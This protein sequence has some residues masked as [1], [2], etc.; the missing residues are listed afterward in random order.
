MSLLPLGPW[1]PQSVVFGDL[2]LEVWGRAAFRVLETQS[3]GV[4]HFLIVFLLVKSYSH[5]FQ[6]ERSSV[7]RREDSER[8]YSALLIQL[9]VTKDII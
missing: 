7:N 9:P 3:K 8:S 1:W 4:T 5:D 6:H 2:L